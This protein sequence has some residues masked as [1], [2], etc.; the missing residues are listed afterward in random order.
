[1]PGEVVAGIESK[2]HNEIVDE[3]I[4][5]DVNLHDSLVSNGHMSPL[6]HVARPFSTQDW[7]EI[8]RVKVG[9]RPGIFL[10]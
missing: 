10:I 9:L 8:E 2:I 5:A 6:E 4:R 1:M 3:Y 7:E